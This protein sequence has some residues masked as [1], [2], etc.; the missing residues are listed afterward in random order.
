MSSFGLV[1]NNKPYISLE[2]SVENLK[3]SKQNLCD[4]KYEFFINYLLSGKDQYGNII[5][6]DEDGNSYFH[7]DIKI[8]SIDILIYILLDSKEY[9][10]NINSRNRFG[11]TA[12]I[13]AIKISN[14]N[15]VKLLLDADIDYTI[16]QIKDKKTP[17]EIAKELNN[18]EIITLLQHKFINDLNEG[19]L[20][21]NNPRI[22]NLISLYFN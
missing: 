22:I 17:I 6:Q 13:I 4:Q 1:M 21:V 2:I 10:L 8:G 12:L 16:P 18:V 15:I 9:K 14:L 5:G 3:K 7:N 11:E 19:K 20:N